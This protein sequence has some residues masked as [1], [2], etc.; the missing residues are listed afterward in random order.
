MFVSDGWMVKRESIRSESV[1]RCSSIVECLST[2]IIN[3][4]LSIVWIDLLDIVGRSTR[5]TSQTH[6]SSRGRCKSLLRRRRRRPIDLYSSSLDNSQSWSGE[7][8]CWTFVEISSR[9]CL[10]P[11]WRT[12]GHRSVRDVLRCWSSLSFSSRFHSIRQMPFFRNVPF[13][14][15][16][17][18]DF[19]FS[20]KIN[21]GC[22]TGRSLLSFSLPVLN[23]WLNTFTAEKFS[24]VIILLT[25]S[26]P[27]E[28]FNE[29]HQH[30]TSISIDCLSRHSFHLFVDRIDRTAGDR[31]S[32]DYLDCD[33]DLCLSSCRGFLVVSIPLLS[34]S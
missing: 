16:R 8:Q 7:D 27:L 18:K 13:G 21:Q 20:V 5:L 34:S 26:S 4:D 32:A 1:V 29:Q 23:D 11:T 14:R 10:S 24:F 15:L 28:G 31:R 25:S 17:V 3:A 33:R 6:D 9:V 30:S 19:M 22:R 12:M 2:F